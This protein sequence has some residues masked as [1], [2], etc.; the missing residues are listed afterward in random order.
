MSEIKNPFALKNNRMVT[1]H[2]LDFSNRGIRCNCTCPIC[3]GSFEAKMGEIRQWHFAHTG[4]PCNSTLRYVNSVYLFV[5]QIISEE[6]MI[7]YPGMELNGKILF[8]DGVLNVRGVEIRVRK[9]GMASGIVLNNGQM[10][11]RL[12]LQI[13]YCVEEIKKPIDD[14]STLIV[15]ISAINH[16]TAKEITDMICYELGIKKWIY[17]KKAERVQHT[18]KTTG[19]EKENN[20]IIRKSEYIQPKVRCHVCGQIV[21]RDDVMMGKSKRH[22]YCHSCIQN[23]GLN[24]RELE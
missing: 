16:M 19:E 17:C 21:H 4:T 5:K 7:Y 20:Q 3:G 6:G 15:D 18:R 14:L 2:D 8:D 24:W 11:I 22:F 23:K 9:D 13:D 10:G 12:K 1:I